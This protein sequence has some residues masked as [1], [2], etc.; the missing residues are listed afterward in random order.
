MSADQ[1]R[2]PY[3]AAHV[4]R[5]HPVQPRDGASDYTYRY[6]GNTATIRGEVAPDAGMLV[7]YNTIKQGLKASHNRSGVWRTTWRY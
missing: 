2:R 1:A 4:C 5:R 6:A 3:M 7:A